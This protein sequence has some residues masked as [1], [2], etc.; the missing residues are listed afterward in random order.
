MYVQ[1]LFNL[2]IQT[3]Y[4]LQIQTLYHLQIQ[5]LHGNENGQDGCRM[6][7]HNERNPLVSPSLFG[8]IK[9]GRIEFVGE[10]RFALFCKSS[11]NKAQLV[12]G[13]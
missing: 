5:M 6:H 3:L 4:P 9:T 7:S 12:C 13:D 11:V 2:Q 8:H 1:T 10:N